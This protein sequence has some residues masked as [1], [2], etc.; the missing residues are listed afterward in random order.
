V[1]VK[2]YKWAFFATG[3]LIGQEYPNILHLSVP[4]NVSLINNRIRVSKEPWEST[5]FPAE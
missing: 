5:G 4:G 3:R 2:D 1:I